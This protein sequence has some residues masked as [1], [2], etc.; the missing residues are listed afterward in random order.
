M[1]PRQLPTFWRELWLERVDDHTASRTAD[2]IR[3]G[4]L[5]ATNGDA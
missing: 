2:A 4:A 1:C 5:A 3:T